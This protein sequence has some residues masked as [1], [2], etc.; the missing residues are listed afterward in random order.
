MGS[1]RIRD[2]FFKVDETGEVIGVQNVV[3][4]AGTFENCLHV[5][6]TGVIGSHKTRL[7]GRSAAAGRYVRDAWFARG[8]GLVKE[9][10][11]GRVEAFWQGDSFAA[12][13]KWEA[14]IKGVKRAPGAVPGEAALAPGIG[15]YGADRPYTSSP[16][17]STS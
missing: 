9:S 3:T 4:P 5:R 10:E 1:G 16:R 7:D 13:F 8:V 14:A 6:Y 17:S 12:T 15:S 11:D 2:D